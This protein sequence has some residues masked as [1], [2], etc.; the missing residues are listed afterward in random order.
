ML[1]VDYY[2]SR[3]RVL[4]SQFVFRFGSASAFLVRSSKRGGWEQEHGTLNTEPNM[5]AN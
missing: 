4:I 1:L 2:S 3:F 5:N